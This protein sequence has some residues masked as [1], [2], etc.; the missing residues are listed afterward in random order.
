MEG[1]P[2]KAWPPRLARSPWERPAAPLC[3]S[4]AGSGRSSSSYR[5][6]FG[7]TPYWYASTP[8]AGARPHIRMGIPLSAPH[9]TPPR[10]KTSGNASTASGTFA[11]RDG[12]VKPI[13]AARSTEG[14]SPLPRR[15]DTTPPRT[16][17]APGSVLQ[18]PKNLAQDGLAREYSLVL[19]QR[20]FGVDVGQGL[21]L[22]TSLLGLQSLLL[23]KRNTSAS[24]CSLGHFS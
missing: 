16:E 7:N 15:S 1:P 23:G 11:A 20:R 9:C 5:L 14:P 21:F 10:E 24:T 17:I 3:S 12:S 18:R 22:G 13:A 19:R 8:A 4:A 6:C 2:Q